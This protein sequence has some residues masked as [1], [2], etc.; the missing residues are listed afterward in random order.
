MSTNKAIRLHDVEVFQFADGTIRLSQ[1]QSLEDPVSIDLHPS[2][3]AYIAEMFACTQQQREAERK[4]HVL[5][6][7]IGRVVADEYVRAEI[8]DRCGDGLAILAELDALDDL[9][10]EYTGG[11]VPLGRDE[12]KK[13]PAQKVDAED[14]AAAARLSPQPAPVPVPPRDKGQLGLTL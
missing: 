10:I 7:K 9:A 12:E 6:E 11:L 14:K 5:A 1:P 4:L 3:L 13:E 2:Q 8:I